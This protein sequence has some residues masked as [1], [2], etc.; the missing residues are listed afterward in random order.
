MAW[1][2]EASMVK[3]GVRERRAG[4]CGNSWRRGG[5]WLAGGVLLTA[6][7]LLA[8]AYASVGAAFGVF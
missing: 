1:E 5:S 6:Q 7:C 3:V 2:Q 4:S 8:L